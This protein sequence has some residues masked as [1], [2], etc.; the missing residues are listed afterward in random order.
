MR[1]KFTRNI[2][3]KAK[4]WR[5]GIQ[6]LKFGYIT[7]MV[8]VNIWAMNLVQKLNLCT[9]FLEYN[10]QIFRFMSQLLQKFSH[11]FITCLLCKFCPIC[12]I[13][14]NFNF[15]WRVHYINPNA[16]PCVHSD[17]YMKLQLRWHLASFLLSKKCISQMK[18]YVFLFNIK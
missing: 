18:Q 11:I 9:L 7:L 16:I 2:R 8:V 12:L 4:H 5:K 17:I 1:K 14:V 15:M 10:D 6:I 13:S 3:S